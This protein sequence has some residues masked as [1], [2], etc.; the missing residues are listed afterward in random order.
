LRDLGEVFLH[1]IFDFAGAGGQVQAEVL[2]QLG[3]QA[4]GLGYGAQSQG[5][6]ALGRAHR[7]LS[8]EYAPAADAKQRAVLHY[9][10]CRQSPQSEAAPENPRKKRF[11]N[12][13]CGR[14]GNPSLAT[15]SNVRNILDVIPLSNLSAQIQPHSNVR[16]LFDTT[17]SRDAIQQKRSPDGAFAPLGL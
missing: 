14:R 8:R 6:R 2:E 12:L 3:D 1:Y 16:N 17:Y 7:R 5:R 13:N 11:S 15:P 9:T 4:F 10:P